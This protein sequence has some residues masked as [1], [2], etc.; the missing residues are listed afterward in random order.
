MHSSSV[1]PATNRAAP[2]RHAMPAHEALDA[3]AVGRREDPL[4]QRRVGCAVQL[5]DSSHSCTSRDPMLEQREVP[6]LVV[7]PGLGAGHVRGEPFAVGH[8]GRSGRRRRA[9][10]AP[11]AEMSATSNPHGATNARLSSIHPSALRRGRGCMSSCIQ[12]ASAPVS[13]ARSAGPRS[14]CEHLAA[15]CSARQFEHLGAIA[16]DRGP[17]RVLAG[18]DEV[19]LLHV[20]LAHACEPVEAFGSPRSHA[21]HGGCRASAGRRRAQRRRARADRRPR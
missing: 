9:R 17:E 5:C 19:E 14:V 6:V 3:R 20:V 16:F 21:R 4:A 13:T 1:S 10:S 7:D 18:E 11:A 15:C 12:A 2:S 8:A